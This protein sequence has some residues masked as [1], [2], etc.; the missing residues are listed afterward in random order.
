MEEMLQESKNKE[1]LS[2]IRSFCNT[3]FYENVASN[4]L[5]DRF[6]KVAINLSGVLKRIENGEH[7]IIADS[8]GGGGK[9]YDMI[10][11]D[12]GKELLKNVEYICVDRSRVQLGT[13]KL[14]GK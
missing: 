12:V 9:I 5:T 11:K 14:K 10:A 8:G 2:K 3:S 7:V 1:V 6:Y 13:D 4:H